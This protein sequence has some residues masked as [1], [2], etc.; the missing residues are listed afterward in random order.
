MKS[1]INLIQQSSHS[2][3]F[4]FLVGGVSCSFVTCVG[5]LIGSKSF[6][7][8]FAANL[9]VTSAA[10]CR[11]FVCFVVLQ[12]YHRNMLCV[13]V[14]RVRCQGEPIGCFFEVSSHLCESSL[15]KC[16]KHATLLDT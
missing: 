6:A 14:T 9:V 2:R 8:R 15:L 3:Q 10:L 11:S 12:M 5:F 7:N 16:A 1:L 4:L 13:F